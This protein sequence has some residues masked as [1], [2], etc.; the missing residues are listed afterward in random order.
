MSLL[1]LYIKD[2]SHVTKFSPIFHLK[3]RPVI[4][5]IMGKGKI[6]V[7]VGQCEHCI[8][9]VQMKVQHVCILSI[10]FASRNGFY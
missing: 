5:S 9:L 2:C 7:G 3:Y 1:Y 10:H 8:R 6:C 4:L